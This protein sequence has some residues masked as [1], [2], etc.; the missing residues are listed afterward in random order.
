MS[1]KFVSANKFEVQVQPNLYLQPSWQKNANIYQVLAANGGGLLG[2]MGNT[3]NGIG[4][5]NNAL[6]RILGGGIS[7]IGRQQ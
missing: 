1:Y 6:E 5:L 7:E 3:G 4:D 2:M